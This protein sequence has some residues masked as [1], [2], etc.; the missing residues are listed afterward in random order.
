MKL[1]LIWHQSGV[2]MYDKVRFKRQHK[3]TSDK[4]NIKTK[5]THYN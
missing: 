2:T 3:H 5:S 1:E 4:L